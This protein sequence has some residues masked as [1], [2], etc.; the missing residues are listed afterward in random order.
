[1]SLLLKC[2]Y[3]ASAS[4]GFIIPVEV[5]G[6]T[7]ILMFEFQY[8]PLFPSQKRIASYNVFEDVGVPLTIYFQCLVEGVI[9]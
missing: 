4:L 6:K 2:F 7:T 1:M 5:R 9:I 8:F 3:Q